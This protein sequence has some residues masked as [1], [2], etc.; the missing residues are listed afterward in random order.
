ML[1][2]EITEDITIIEPELSDESLISSGYGG[3]GIRRMIKTDN[4]I[5]VAMGGLGSQNT[6]YVFSLDGKYIRSIGSRGQ[7]PGE[8][9]YLENITFDDKNNR[10]FILSNNPNKIICYHLD[11]KFVYIGKLKN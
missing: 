5:I 4:E 10:L 6:V 1:L 7:G 2:S 8:H 3:S 11:G 9:N